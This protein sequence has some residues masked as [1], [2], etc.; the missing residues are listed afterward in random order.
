[1]HGQ[2]GYGSPCCN[3][4]RVLMTNS[5]PSHRMTDVLPCNDLDASACFYAR[6]GFKRLDSKRPKP[7]E[8]DTYRM[9]SDG[10]GAH[11]HLTEAVEGWLVPGRNP[12]GLY[13]HSQHVDSLA[14]A[15]AGEIVGAKE[16]QHKPWGMYE[17]ALSDPDETLVRWPTRL[18]TASQKSLFLQRCC[19]LPRSLRSAHPIFNKARPIHEE[20]SSRISRPGLADGL[21][22]R[23]RSSIKRPCVP[24]VAMP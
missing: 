7:G 5:A 14:A 16:P 6:L 3:D 17:F 12:F 22:R 24:A 2:V 11:L 4:R 19:S 8:P 18:Y 23:L 20:R 1:M 9:P 15:F 21:A 13:L 10:E